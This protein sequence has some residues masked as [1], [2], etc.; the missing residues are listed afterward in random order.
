[1]RKA[2]ELGFRLVAVGEGVSSSGLGD[3]DGVGVGEVFFFFLDFGFGV[4]LGSGVGDDFLCFGVSLGSGVGDAFL[5]LGVCS[6]GC[7]AFFACGCPALVKL[8]YVW[9]MNSAKALGFL[10]AP[11]AFVFAPASAW[12]KQRTFGFFRLTTLRRG[13]SARP[14]RRKPT[15]AKPELPSSIQREISLKPRVPATP[16]CSAASRL[17]GSRAGNS[18]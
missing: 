9:E 8:S 17:R 13:L 4:S 11:Y 15:A 1:M 10:S 6:V 18:R 14:R 16:P 12:A 5:C 2:T 3:S 7:D